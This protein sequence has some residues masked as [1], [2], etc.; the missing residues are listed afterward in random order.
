ME[1]RPH[2]SAAYKSPRAHR[3]LHTHRPASPFS[4]D[5]DI[6]PSLRERGSVRSTLLQS[7]HPTAASHQHEGLSSP[8]KQSSRRSPPSPLPPPAPPPSI[9]L[10]NDVVTGEEGPGNR[11]GRA[12]ARRARHVHGPASPL[13]RKR[14]F[15][16]FEARSCDALAA[17][18]AMDR[19]GPFI[20]L[21]L[22]LTLCYLVDTALASRCGSMEA[23]GPAVLPAVHGSRGTMAPEEGSA[24]ASSREERQ[25]AHNGHWARAWARTLPGAKGWQQR[26]C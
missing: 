22:A 17:G 15:R 5:R 6:E 13:G 23:R 16:S 18:L 14:S 12:P 21:A 1:N 26:C 19:R 25:L 24:W 7:A 2:L 8:P 20:G 11:D 3:A 9:Q 10:F 4:I